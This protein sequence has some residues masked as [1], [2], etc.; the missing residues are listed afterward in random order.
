MGRDPR[1]EFVMAKSK[2]GQLVGGVFA[3]LVLFSCGEADQEDTTDDGM[4][5][6]GN[7]AAGL[8]P[9][10][11]EMCGQSCVSLANNSVHCGACNRVCPIGSTCIGGACV[12]QAGLVDCGGVCVDPLGDALNCGSCGSACLSGQVCSQ[13]TC[14]AVCAGRC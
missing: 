2:V 9:V 7:A 14:S 6:A 12:C 13:G 4:A 5:G 11:L 1:A 3:G 10:G 8:C